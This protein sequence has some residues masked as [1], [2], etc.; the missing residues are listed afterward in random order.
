MCGSFAAAVKIK[1]RKNWRPIKPLKVRLARMR[2]QEIFAPTLTRARNNLI[3]AR[4]F[5]TFFGYFQHSA[6]NLIDKGFL[7]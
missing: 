4:F 1:R 7:I 5:E 6:R 3:L 2:K